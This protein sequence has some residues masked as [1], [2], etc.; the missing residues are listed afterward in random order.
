MASSINIPI[1]EDLAIYLGYPIHHQRLNKQTFQCLIDKAQSK[2]AGWK[3]KCLS[4]AGGSTLIIN[5]AILSYIAQSNVL[6]KSITNRL[7]KI[8]RQFLWG[9]TPAGKETKFMLRV[10]NT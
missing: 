7:D 4:M 10:L 5:S 3:V 2:V 8:N 9:S 6:P 1:S